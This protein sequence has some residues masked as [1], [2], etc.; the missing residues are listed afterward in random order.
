MCHRLTP[1]RNETTD[2]T[3]NSQLDLD[4]IRSRLITL[5]DAFVLEKSTAHAM[6]E[7][8]REC[9]IF[10]DQTTAFS[11]LH[12]HWRG[13]AEARDHYRSTPRRLAMAMRHLGLQPCVLHSGKTRAYRGI[14]LTPEAV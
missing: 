4:A 5:P 2:M 12:S 1:T 6:Q 10:T 13:W 9:C 14:A 8:L 3:P 7:W 11:D